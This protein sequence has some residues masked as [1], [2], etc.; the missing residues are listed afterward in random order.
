MPATLL[1]PSPAVS[2]KTKPT[3][4]KKGRTG[5]EGQAIKTWGGVVA[6]A[7]CLGLIAGYA[8]DARGSLLTTAA[9]L[10]AAGGATF[11]IG[12]SAARAARR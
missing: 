2:T 8:M 7:S 5:R 4:Q 6:I 11:W 12:F 1:S 3:F 10:A 9:C